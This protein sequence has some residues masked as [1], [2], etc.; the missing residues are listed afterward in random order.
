MTEFTCPLPILEHRHIVMGHGG[1]GRLMHQLIESVFK[2]RFGN[3]YLAQSHDGALLEIAGARLAFTTDA[4]VVHP[5]FFPGGDIGRLAVCGTV[6]DLAMCGARPLFLSVAFVLEEGL[7]VSVLERVAESV[8]RAA[9]EANV[10]VVTGDTKVVERGK[11]DGLYLT[12]A[13][14]GVLEHRLAIMPGSVR[15]GDVI[16]L[17]GDVGRHGIAVLAVR[18][19]M[20]L[21]PGITSDVASVW[22]LV[23]VLLD[24]GVE[25][26][27]MR[28]LTRGGLA[29]AL[30]EIA[31]ASG[32]QCEV[33]EDAIPVLSNVRGACELLGL[34]PLYVACE[35]RF[36]A[37]VAESDAERAVELLRGV[38]GGENACV[39][40]R[41]LDQ[42]ARGREVVI[43]TRLGVRRIL[44]MP[45]GE[46]LPRIC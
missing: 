17:S 11:C 5:L 22:P 46:Q 6:N 38:P 35:G 1:G 21:D 44:D 31:A 36:V 26:H 4:H 39:I 43:V 42:A 8:Q 13:G 9:E 29:S 15:P 23:H 28:D 30:N 27:C 41:V 33:M 18:E 37:F 2:P 16:V 14:L 19:G 10:Q 40:G 25:V 20:G 3:P 24:A 45:L 7:E 32:R 12:T 34:D